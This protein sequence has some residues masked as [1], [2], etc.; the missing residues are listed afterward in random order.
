[1][2]LATM[3]LSLTRNK[4]FLLSDPYCISKRHLHH[5]YILS[6]SFGGSSSVVRG[7]H[8]QAALNLLTLYSVCVALVLI[9]ENYSATTKY[10]A[11]QPVTITNNRLNAYAREQ[12]QRLLPVGHTCTRMFC[13]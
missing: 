2:I 3:V 7:L 12:N 13:H 1:M 11:V 10:L 8:S 4:N 6:A 9:V 5:Q